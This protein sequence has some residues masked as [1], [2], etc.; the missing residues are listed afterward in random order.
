LSITPAVVVLATRWRT[1]VSFGRCFVIGLALSIGGVVITTGAFRGE[2]SDV[3][4]VACAFGAVAS[5]AIYRLTV[6]RLAT[7]A[8]PGL[9]S[10]WIYLVH[11]VLALVLIAPLVGVPS[12]AAWIAGAWTGIAAA[13]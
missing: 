2:S 8:D 12:H 10:S 11:G 5:S 4:G 13:V 9:I 3:M 6:E 1:G 7:S